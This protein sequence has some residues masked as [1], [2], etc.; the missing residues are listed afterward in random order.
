MSIWR[1][2]L[3]LSAAIAPLPVASQPAPAAGIVGHWQ[4]ELEQKGK[5]LRISYDFSSAP[6]GVAVKF[7]APA[8]SVMD[9]PLGP[10]KLDGDDI[11]FEMGGNSLTGKRAG[12]LIRGA[13]KGDDGAGS[14]VLRRMPKPHLPYREIPVTFRNGSVTLAGTLAMPA[15]S[16]RHPA[17]VLLQ[18]S[19][20][21]VRWG[22]NRYIADQ[23]A[24]AGIAALAYDKRGSGQSTGDVHDGGYDT[25][26]SD[27][28][29][30]VRML[31]KRAD[32]DP[33]R[34]GL[35][36]H[37]EGG[38]VAPLAATLEPGR[39]AF[40]VAEDTYAG[41]V[42]DQDIYRTANEIKAENFGDADKAK[43]LAMYTLFIQVLSGDRPYADLE[44]AI[45]PVKEEPWFKDLNLPARDNP[46][47]TWYPRRAHFDTRSAWAKVRQPVLLIYGEHDELVP[48]DESLRRIEDLLD[49]SKTPYTALIAPRAQ[50]NLTIKPEGKDPFFWWHKAPG[51]IETV[52][53]WVKAC[54]ARG[55]LCHTAQAVDSNNL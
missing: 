43:Q 41:R 53:E 46:V 2:A 4:G 23:F 38:M 29:A 19:G 10:A 12:N 36:G 30:G 17:V 7:S 3:G 15:T 49:A 1:I 27:A 33:A 45:L 51:V 37:S 21:E 32:I 48:V 28:L 31:Q 22:T 55:G 11:S 20:P 16:G 26:A 13:F 9:Y 14:F 34:I 39:I 5:A 44:A 52:V 54:T 50:H 42:S 47:W 40:I 35:H 25:L 6:T 8:W 24:R 18:G